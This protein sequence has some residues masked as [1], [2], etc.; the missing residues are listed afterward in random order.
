MTHPQDPDSPA[1]D[2][3]LKLESDPTV[4]LDSEPL[5]GASADSLDDLPLGPTDE[6]AGASGPFHTI[7]DPNSRGGGPPRGVIIALLTLAVLLLGGAAFIYLRPP[8]NPPVSSEIAEVEEPVGTPIV[9]PEDGDLEAGLGDEALDLGEL[10]PLDES[11][12]LVR[13]VAGRLSRHPS[14][15]RVLATDDLVRR[16][17]VSVENIANGQSPRQHLEHLELQEPFRVTERDG[18]PTIDPNSYRRYD[19]V[20]SAFVS[21]EAQ[22]AARLYR[23]L[24]PRFDEAYRDLGYPS[25]RFRSS[26]TRAC[27][28]LLATPVP[29]ADPTLTPR[30][31]TYA[32]ADVD[33]ENLSPAQRQL[34]RTGPENVRR[35]QQQLRELGEA[36]ELGL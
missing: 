22:D 19:P 34:L 32:Y 27:R 21:V 11:D 29:P 3:T 18:L 14:L 33:Y 25:G 13:E 23:A 35:V 9:I 4:R 1:A 31:V 26:L 30:V 7:E 15:A 28:Q 5:R 17:V 20:I 10:P 36:L 2:P 12:E 24:E 16:T 6:G 8:A